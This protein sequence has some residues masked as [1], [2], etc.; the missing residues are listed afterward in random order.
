MVPRFLILVLLLFLPSNSY[1]QIT[2][3]DWVVG[4][5]LKTLAKIY[6]K[7]SNLPK[8]KSK[9]IRKIESM[10]VE[11]FSRSYKKFY[12]LY[13]QLPADLKQKYLFTDQSTKSDVIEVIDRINK[14]DLMAII[15][16]IPGEFIVKQA[17][18]YSPQSQNQ[19]PAQPH[20]IFLWRSIVQRI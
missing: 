6:V 11:K 9:Y 17:I 10:K 3:H 12:L 4:G 2:L 19:L 1:A 14:K 8:L 15:N 5:A 16:R 18:K 7:T 13:E 20:A